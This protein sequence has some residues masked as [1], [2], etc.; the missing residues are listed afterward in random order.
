MK[1]M[2]VGTY[3]AATS[4]KTGRA[5]AAGRKASVAGVAIGAAASAGGNP[6]AAGTPEYVAWRSGHITYAAAGANTEADNCADPAKFNTPSLAIA[7]DAG[8][9]TGATY[10]FTPSAPGL[11]VTIDFGDGLYATN[12]PASVAAISH[13]YAA[14]GTYAIRLGFLD[15]IRASYSQAVTI[16]P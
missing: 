7:I 1:P 10:T 4:P 12:P 8:D 9:T 16:T 11:P 15:K 5:Y 14:S 3:Q 13:K 2:N 6:H